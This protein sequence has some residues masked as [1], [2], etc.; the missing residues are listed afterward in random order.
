[1]CGLYESVGSAQLFS[2]C[3]CERVRYEKEA[4]FIKKTWLG[5][6][7]HHTSITKPR[8]FNYNWLWNKI[9]VSVLS[10]SFSFFRQNIC[11]W[12]RCCLITKISIYILYWLQITDKENLDK[13]FLMVPENVFY[14]QSN[15]SSTNQTFL[16]ICTKIQ[17][18]TVRF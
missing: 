9:S 6:W 7:L 5:I 12:W 10:I 15:N 18:Q 4:N 17:W 16:E 11:R 8:T 13:F 14:W 1:M 2:L 3:L